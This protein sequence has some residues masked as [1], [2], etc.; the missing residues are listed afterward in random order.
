MK[1]RL[2]MTLTIVLV[3]ILAG[4]TIDT[5][6][7]LDDTVWY[8]LSLGDQAAL[9]DTDVIILFEDGRMGGNDGCNWYGGAYTVRGDRFSVDDEIESTLML[10]SEPVMEQARA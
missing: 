1:T 5:N 3:V 9:P 4:C 2:G 7:P 8:M 10:C 6:D